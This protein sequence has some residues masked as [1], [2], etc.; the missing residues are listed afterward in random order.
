VVPVAYAIQAAA[1]AP[2]ATSLTASDFQLKPQT[3]A[4]PALRC[5][6]PRPGEI[7]VC[8]RRGQGQRLTAL[9]LPA[10][11]KPKQSAGIDF[12]G[13]RIEPHMH[14]EGMPQGRVSKRFTIDFL[15]PF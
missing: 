10:G 8:G 2:A 3:P 6:E 7:L 5:P 12:G 9:P 1:P 4:D 15:M 14:E 13:G 11:V